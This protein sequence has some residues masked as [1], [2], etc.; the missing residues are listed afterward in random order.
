LSLGFEDRRLTALRLEDLRLLRSLGG[1]DRGATVTLGSHLLLHR[2]L[3]GVGRVDGLQLDARHPQAPLA[4]RLIEDDAQLT[5][6]VVPA[7][8]RL[9]EIET[10]DDVAQRGRGEL[11]DGD[12]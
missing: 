5:V 6:D 4:G 7:G 8:E 10:A 1:E 12:R 2:V 11:F 3:D 9:F